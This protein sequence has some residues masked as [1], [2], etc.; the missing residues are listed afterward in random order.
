MGQ[1]L[2]G[3]SDKAGSKW[4]G[5]EGPLPSRSGAQ[6]WR[7]AGGAQV[8]GTEQEAQQ[9]EKDQALALGAA[10]LNPSAKHYVPTQKSP[11]VSRG[12]DGKPCPFRY[13]RSGLGEGE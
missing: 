3:E 10:E 7:A 12:V 8:P 4:G 6:V 2:C 1:G 9:G 5:K 13:F 11:W